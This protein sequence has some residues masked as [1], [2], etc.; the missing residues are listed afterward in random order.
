MKLNKTAK[1]QDWRVVFDESIQVDYAQIPT[2]EIREVTDPDT[3]QTKKEMVT[4]ERMSVGFQ[5]ETGRGRGISWIPTEEFEPALE[6]LQHYAKNGVDSV[7]ASEDWL[8]PTES[9]HETITKVPRDG[10]DGYDIAFRVRL[11][12]GSKSCRVPEE[13]FAEFVAMLTD[14]AEA[15]PDAV[16]AVEEARAE[17]EAKAAAKAA[18]AAQNS[19]D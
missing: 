10:G 3:N 6:A 1:A 16:L 8:N 5:T 14:T 19:D 18:K 7:S 11:G 13:D 15:I 4:V 2:G 12:K 9:I 17:A